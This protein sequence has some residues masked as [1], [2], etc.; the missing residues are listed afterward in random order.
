MKTKET[1]KTYK[2]KGLEFYITD[3]VNINHAVKSFVTYR[4]GV[5]ENDIEEFTGKVP[6][7]ANVMAAVEYPTRQLAL[8]WWGSINGSFK[9][10]DLGLKYYPNRDGLTGREI[11]KIWFEETQPNYNST[12]RDEDYSASWGFGTD[13]PNQK[14]LPKELEGVVPRIL[15]IDEKVEQVKQWNKKQF[16]EFN[17][18]LFRAYIDKF[19]DEDKLEMLKI[20][21]H[22][23]N[24]KTSMSLGDSEIKFQ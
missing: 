10:R 6:D 13:K 2:T 24:I 23:Q 16:K 5:T 14:Q 21:F 15:T 22:S 17:P 12:N 20:L 1:L 3:A 8:E 19:S 18:E 4:I 11:E 9:Q 7:T